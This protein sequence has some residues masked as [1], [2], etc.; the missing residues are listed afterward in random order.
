MTESQI[1]T[2]TTIDAD[3]FEEVNKVVR[4]LPRE[5]RIRVKWFLQDSITPAPHSSDDF[6][7]GYGKVTVHLR[8]SNLIFGR[9]R[10]V[11]T[12]EWKRPY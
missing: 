9:W 8:T 4:G 3:V 2:N 6:F 5:A 1:E 12:K 7:I 10:L 11:F